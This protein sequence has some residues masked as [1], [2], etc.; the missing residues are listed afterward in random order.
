[1][2][3]ALAELKVLDLSMNLPGP[4]LTC[5]LAELGA[6]VVKVENP[7]GGDYGRFMGGQQGAGSVYF[8]AVN[9]HKKSLALN[10]KHPRGKDLFLAL[11][12]THDV[13]VE[14]FRPGVMARLGLDYAKTS[15]LYPALIQVSITGYGSSGSHAQRAG[16]DINYLALAGVLG[17]SGCRQGELAQPGIQAA[18]LFG[19]SLLAL[20]GLLAAVI[21]RERTGQGQLVDVAMFDGS[22]ALAAMVFAGVA[23]GLEEPR[24]GGMTLNGRSPCYGLYQTKDGAW[25]SLGAL[26]PKFWRNFC[27]AVERPD[28]EPLQFGGPRAVAQ[29]AELFASRTREQWSDLFADHDACAEP[30]LDLKEMAASPLARERG[31]VR[32]D[33]S[34]RPTISCPLRLSASPLP[35]TGQAPRLGQHSAPILAGLGLSRTEIEQ[36]AD[37]GVT[38]LDDK[39]AAA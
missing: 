11:L 19:G 31:M 32:E 16:H 8:Q 22:V 6:Q 7:E 2:K 13:L 20:A 4:Y 5:L 18:D 39:A 21:Q 37:Q 17:L 14:G 1:M 15:A 35:P 9:R 26:E 29:V 33:P 30:V 28:L 10:L 25:F 24:P 36:L 27:R 3:R 34:G 23:A 12:E 38:R